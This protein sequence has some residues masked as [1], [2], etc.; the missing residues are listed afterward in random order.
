MHCFL[1]WYCKKHL[2]TH[3]GEK[4]MQCRGYWG[5]SACQ[6]IAY[7]PNSMHHY[8][9]RCCKK[10]QGHFKVH[11]GEKS[12]QCRGYWSKLA[13]QASAYFSDSSNPSNSMHHYCLADKGKQYKAGRLGIWVGSFQLL[14]SPCPLVR[15]KKVPHGLSSRRARSTK[16]TG[17]LEVVP[18]RG[19]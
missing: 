17:P 7:Q 5:K 8:L 14:E 4:S 16:S 10:K 9:L 2:K 15:H 19:P 13:C 1:L 12:M 11:T 6:A 3:T 18:W